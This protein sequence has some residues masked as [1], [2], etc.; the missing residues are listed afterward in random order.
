MCLSL[1]FA[2]L[3]L[4]KKPASPIFIEWLLREKNLYQSA[5]V[6]ILG[7]I[8]IFSLDASFLDLC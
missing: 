6:D 7:A 1:C 4:E 5:Q 3:A 2:I 8:Q